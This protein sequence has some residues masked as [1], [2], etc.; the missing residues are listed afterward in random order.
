[1]GLKNHYGLYEVIYNDEGEISAHTE[2][3]E[4]IADTPEELIE[5]LEIMLKRGL[6]QWNGD[7][8]CPM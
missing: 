6:E 3:P 5:S 2:E 8:N 7:L 4:V 1:M